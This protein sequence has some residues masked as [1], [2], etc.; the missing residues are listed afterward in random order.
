[1]EPEPQPQLRVV[2]E[3]RSGICLNQLFRSLSLRSNSAASK[4]PA[5]ESPTSPSCSAA[6]SN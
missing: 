4:S 6:T 5:L 3:S 2:Q 1:V